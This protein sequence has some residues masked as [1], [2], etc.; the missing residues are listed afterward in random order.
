[1]DTKSSTNEQ[2]T[3]EIRAKQA[4][5]IS[6]SEATQAPA[7]RTT[8]LDGAT[9][10][11]P[12]PKPPKAENRQETSPKPPTKDPSTTPSQKR[13]SIPKEGQ[14]SA[15]ERPP[16]PGSAEPRSRSR[17]ASGVEAS[18]RTFS[19]DDFLIIEKPVPAAVKAEGRDPSLLSR[20]TGST[21]RK[22]D[23]QNL[24]PEVAAEL[25]R[26]DQ[27]L[28]EMRNYIEKLE[29]RIV[30]QDIEI[31]ALNT[32]LADTEHKLDLTRQDL[33]ASRA[34]VSSEGT[35]DAQNLI[36]S[37]RELNS[38]IDDFAFRFTQEALPE[39]AT[40][41]KVTHRGLTA[42]GA[43]YYGAVKIST[44]INVAYQRKATVGDFLH[45][46]VCYALC[47]RLSELVFEPFVPGLENEMS[48][49][50]KKIYSTVNSNE[51]QDKS[52]RWRALT[53][54][55][56]YRSRNITEYVEKGADDFLFKLIDAVN[57]LTEL[58]EKLTFENVQKEL[59]DVARS[60]FTEAFKFQ[61]TACT[62]YLSY[63][64]VPF[65]SS[66]DQPFHPA[67]METAQEVRQGGR[68]KSSTAILTIGLGL[69]AWKS[70][71][72][73]DKTISK[74]YSIAVKANVIC[75]N[76]DPNGDS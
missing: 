75:G 60:I 46:F 13:P 26:R 56:V 40:S 67:Y 34:F 43:N 55:S 31:S 54:S 50:F 9:K 27:I 64:Y 72:K 66:A 58:E 47:Q 29:Q 6:A 68:G 41:A 30:S 52:G 25:Q 44:F 59:G 49:I 8:S 39:S 57:A 24:P 2:Q 7:P 18:P 63:D 17:K 23:S 73:E 19:Q 62:N 35:A 33:N 20:I 51:P 48:D 37:L 15:P 53:F 71:V 45:P 22:A 21:G 4:A 5:S 70:V 12:L 14:Q 1:M 76:W 11:P 28:T 36:K 61:E 10:R 42:F 3:T 16:R 38:A 69:Q 32:A 65:L 74:D